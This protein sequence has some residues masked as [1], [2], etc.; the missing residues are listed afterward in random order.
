MPCWELFD[1]QDAAYRESVL[2]PAVPAR[3]AVEAGIRQGWDKY[4]GSDGRF[5]GMATFGKSGP[6][7]KLYSYF[8]ITP[9]HR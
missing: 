3:V 2:P 5:V 6:Y 1:E 8:G 4:I 9:E 7:Q